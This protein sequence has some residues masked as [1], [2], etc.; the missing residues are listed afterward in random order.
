LSIQPQGA[1][2]FSLSW[3]TNNEGG[4][5]TA[6]V[7]MG[8]GLSQILPLIVQGVLARKG[9]T[10]VAEQPEIHLNPKLQT[11]LAELFSWCIDREVSIVTETH[12]EHLLLTTRRLLA[13]KELRPD[14]VALYFVE[15]DERDSDIQEVPL[16]DDGHIPS[17]DWPSGFFGDA[18]RESLALSA[19]QHKG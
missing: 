10:I 12:S 11:V 4:G 8:F 18:L 19:A 6:F 1:G 3:G 17:E 9:S 7:D 5:N 13:E 14:E 16:S 2:A 15:R